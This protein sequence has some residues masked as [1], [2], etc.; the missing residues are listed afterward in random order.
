MT[1]ENFPH[2]RLRRLALG[3]EGQALRQQLFS[4]A[5]ALLIATLVLMGTSL[6]NL[7]S[8][9]QESEAAEDCMLEITTIES[10]LVDFDRALGAYALTGDAR[11]QVFMDN[12]YSELGIA[13]AKLHH[14]LQNKPEQLKTYE[15][16]A[17]MLHEWQTLA[18]EL[19]KP[20]HRN[21]LSKLPAWRAEKR[22]IAQA[23]GKLWQILSPERINRYANNR[24]MIAEA[25]SSFWLAV[26]FIVI[27]LFASLAFFG[28]RNAAG[29]VRSKAR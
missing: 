4:A 10:R 25:R 21:D 19:R 27:S 18:R 7:R 20:E 28:I 5:A 11:Y 16:L 6:A 13:A 2:S 22:L 24:K 1:A 23:R 29:E 8:S 12:T 26:V 3:E 14:S 17:G 9:L 15:Q